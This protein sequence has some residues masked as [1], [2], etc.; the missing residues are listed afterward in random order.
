[1]RVN[2]AEQTISNSGPSTWGIVCV[3]RCAQ[4]MLLSFQSYLIPHSLGLLKLTFAVNGEANLHNNFFKFIFV[5]KL[6]AKFYTH[7]HMCMCVYTHTHTIHQ[8]KTYNISN[9][10]EN[11]LASGQY[12]CPEGTA[13]HGLP[14]SAFPLHIYG[15]HALS[16]FCSISCLPDL[17]TYLYSHAIF[18]HATEAHS[19]S[20]E[21]CIPLHEYS[22]IYPFQY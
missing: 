15:Q 13:N 6:F 9:T 22:T 21:D 19:F 12:L 3:S 16:T 7:T 1:M 11:C 18:T 14:L 2:E 10:A 5:F 17:P 20:L 4:D 8:I